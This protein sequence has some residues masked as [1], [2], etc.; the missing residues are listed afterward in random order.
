MPARRRPGPEST[1]SIFP[2]QLRLGDRFTDADG[3][4]EVVSQPVTFKHGHEVRA[5]VERPDDPRAARE[6][7]W[8]A[9]EKIAIRRTAG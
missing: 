1:V 9:H 3:E 2:N 4:W 5:R 8:P 7:Y 6:K